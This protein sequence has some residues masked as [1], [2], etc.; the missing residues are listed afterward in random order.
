VKPVIILATARTRSSMVASVFHAHGLW[1]GST[2]RLRAGYDSFENSQIKAYLKTTYGELP[3]RF[4]DPVPGIDKW[5]DNVPHGARMA[6]KCAVA[7]FPVFKHLN[8]C[9]IYVKRDVADT[10]TSFMAKRGP[11]D[12]RPRKAVEAMIAERFAL[13][14]ELRDRHG[15]V[16]V[17]T[18]AVMSG[19][20][21]TLRRAVEY[22]GIDYDPE[23]TVRGI[24]T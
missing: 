11:Q 13:M 24:H 9:W 8:P 12:T 4:V 17:D 3:A 14:D 10:A 18:D 22:C 7:Y 21:S 1:F 23:K 20:R 6:F 16:S 5:L 15:G 2:D 19:D